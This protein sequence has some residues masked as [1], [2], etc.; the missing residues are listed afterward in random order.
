MPDTCCV[1]RNDIAEVEG[2]LTELDLCAGSLPEHRGLVVGFLD[3]DSDR[4]LGGLLVQTIVT[5]DCLEG[6]VVKIL[7]LLIAKCYLKNNDARERLVQLL[8]EPHLA[9]F[10]VPS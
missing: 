4:D 3:L 8:L 6:E 10:L 5:G 1:S 2:S 9:S 7:K